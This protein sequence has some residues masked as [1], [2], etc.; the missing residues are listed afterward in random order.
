MS[1]TTV[2]LAVALFVAAG[3]F[4]FLRG[5]ENVAAAEVYPERQFAIPDRHEVARLFIAD[6]TG[7]S[8]DLTRQPDGT[9]LIDD[10]LKA[11]QTIVEQALATLEQL[12]IDHV[13]TRATA[14]A[15]RDRLASRAL[16]VEAY[17]AAGRKLTGVLIGGSVARG[18]GSYMVVD[19]YEDVFAVRRGMLTGTLRPQFDLRSVAAWRSQDFIQYDP[20]DIQ[21]VELRYP[22]LP[23]RSFRV[24]RGRDGLT[25]EPLADVV[26]VTQPTP[27]QPRR[28]E[29][30]LE[31]FA[32]VP[33]A[34]WAN[35]HA[36]RDSVS[37]M[38]PFAQLIVATKD[39]RDTF[40]LQP[41]A[42]VNERGIPDPTQPFTNYWVERGRED[43]VT[44]QV[45]QVEPI[46]RTYQSFF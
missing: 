38:Q 23:S 4:F 2:L 18:A 9:W 35:D 16:K 36:Y 14:A 45:H 15:Q 29:S 20:V 28:I 33:L 37:A 12:R 31:A 25:V 34:R 5:R 40:E 1:K 26:G 43:F 39:A 42:L 10:T 3:A 32:N 24:E 11:R 17:D 13:P 30:Y 27:A 8:M 7:R 46:L 21:F 41:A 6:M 44:V 19:G 22:R